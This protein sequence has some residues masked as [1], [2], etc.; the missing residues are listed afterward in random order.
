VPHIYPDA[1]AIFEAD[2]VDQCNEW[3]AGQFNELTTEVVVL[4]PSEWAEQKRY[5]PPQ[6][7][8]MPG[9]YRFAV[10]PYL[11]E[12]V[13]C[14]SP[15]SPVRDVTVMKGVQV[16]FT[17]G[18]LENAIGYYMDHVKNAPMMLLTADDQLA[19]LRMNT[20]I[21]PML[22]H[23]G[24]LDLIESADIT[25]KR[26][27]GK[28][29][30]K[31]EWHG[32]G[33][34]ILFGAQN[35]DK[36][37]STS[38]QIL[39]EDEIDGYPDR[40][41]KDGD[42]L[43]LVEDRTAAYEATRKIFRGS[44]PLVMQTSKVH[45]KFL[46]GDQRRNFLPCRNCGEM[47]HLVW[48]KTTDAGDRYGIK[49]DLD[50]DDILVPDSVRYICMKCEFPM[51]ND[52]KIWMLPRGEWQATARPQ[53][54]DFRSYHIP[55]LLS[56]VGMQ[57]WETQVRKW[58]EA[59]DIKYNRPRNMNKLQT[60]YNN[61]LGEPF[62]MEGEGAD[63]LHIRA[64]HQRDYLCGDIPNKHAVEFTGGPVQLVTCAVDVAD[65]KLDIEVRGW[66]KF[67]RY[68]VL[69]WLQAFGDCGNLSSDPWMQLRDRILNK[70]YIADDG[71]QYKIWLTLIDS[72]HKTDTVYKF[73]HQFST[74]VLPIQ[75]RELP[76]KF[77]TLSE[78]SEYITKLGTRAF[79][80]TVSPYKDALMSAFKIEWDGISK[81]PAGHPNFAADLPDEY[82]KQLAGETKRQKF[83]PRTRQPAGWEWH[84]TR[85][86]EALDLAVYNSAALDM[87]IYETCLNSL[88]MATPDRD[89]FW[90]YVAEKPTFYVPG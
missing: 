26:K 77:A 79:N 90:K 54:P 85:D 75:G 35:A 89:A 84:R 10:A 39:L 23:S 25:N 6:V 12:I 68:Y 60:F 41:G 27:T 21:T 28:T 87:V 57:T 29:D 62:R 65:D 59:W 49:F 45:V 34:L 48:N 33:F 4:S 16:C 82:Y 58:L 17:V 3:L 52:D 2:Y 20:Y 69:D 5:L 74:G 44:T 51:V 53:H 22:Q 86:N 14:L 13:D 43:T 36:L 76:P 32:G 1:P 42:P 64:L 83:N 73:C 55:A 72:G 38:I 7:T 15:R 81:Q 56:P 46:A 24:L 66:C 88:G 37:R 67:G 11:R 78:F 31:I 50:A 18:I 71:A 63:P 19:K 30:R 9:P 70:V 47:Q 8:S 40:V 80:V 61:V